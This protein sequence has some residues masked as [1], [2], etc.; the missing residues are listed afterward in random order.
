VSV[1]KDIESLESRPPMWTD[2]NRAKYDRD[3][4]R[5]PS[6]VTDEE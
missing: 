3:K 5:H 4:L 6:G 2:E 1:S